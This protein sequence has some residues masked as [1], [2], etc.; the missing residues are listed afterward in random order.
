M[1]HSKLQKLLAMVSI[2][3]LHER[4]DIMATSAAGPPSH[5]RKPSLMAAGEMFLRSPSQH[6][7]KMQ[8]TDS[9]V[10]TVKGL[11]RQKS[12]ASAAGLPYGPTVS[13]PRADNRVNVKP[14]YSYST[15]DL[16][17]T[18]PT[19]PRAPPN[20]PKSPRMFASQPTVDVGPVSHPG[21]LLPP[22]QSSFD[23]PAASPLPE[24]LL[25]KRLATTLQIRDSSI[26]QDNVTADFEIADAT[27]KMP[28]GGADGEA[29]S[30]KPDTVNK[31]LQMHPS[32]K[33]LQQMTHK[34][35]QDVWDAYHTN[36]VDGG[37]SNKVLQPAELRALSRDVIELILRNYVRWLK[38]S[39]QSKKKPLTEADCRAILQVEKGY[40]LPGKKG[41]T[42]AQ[43]INAMTR[44]LTG[45][46]T[47]SKARSATPSALKGS[48]PTITQE[49]FCMAFDRAMRD[50]LHI[51]IKDQGLGCSIQ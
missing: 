25:R 24:T 37:M 10:S 8:A 13:T 40:L 29:D 50:C 39:S 6:G 22:R 15:D 44:H 12:D 11:R 30:S 21:L 7:R 27:V 45:Q 33:S 35:K 32:I 28:A 14:S 4:I 1:M 18:Q 47:A 34:Q 51:K 3:K 17:T 26:Y 19:T 36:V 23:F 16:G 2:R 48:I 42:D 49:L 46:M 41:Q 5:S 38:Q 9:G 20:I 31:L 43:A